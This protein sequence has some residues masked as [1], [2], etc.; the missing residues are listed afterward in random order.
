MLIR[1]SCKLASYEAAWKW[2]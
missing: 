1:V 2:H